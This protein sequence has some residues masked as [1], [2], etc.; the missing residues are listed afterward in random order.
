MSTCVE[1]GSNHHARIRAGALRTGGLFWILACVW[2]LATPQATAAP[3]TL[4]PAQRYYVIALDDGRVFVDL[5]RKDGIFEKQVLQVFR[6]NVTFDHPVTGAKLVGTTYL[7]DITLVEISD[8][9]SIA[10]AQPSIL[11]QLKPGYEVRFRPQDLEAVKS[12][13]AQL[14]VLV[15]ELALETETWEQRVRREMVRYNNKN[16]MI[17][18]YTEMVQ[19]APSDA[20]SRTQMDFTYRLFRGV[21]AVRFGLGGMNGV[22][23]VGEDE[24]GEPI[25]DRVAYYFGYSSLELKLAPY[26]SFSPI[27][28]M[29]LNNSG[30]GYGFGVSAR[31]GPELGTNLEIHGATA[32]VVGAQ[33]GLSYNHYINERLALSGKVAWENYVTGDSDHPS[34]RV[35][36]GGHYDVLPTI[37][38]DV[39]GG[40]GGRDVQNIGPTFFVGLTYNF[41]TGLWWMQELEDQ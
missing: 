8:V 37:R 16:N 22:G 26:F 28:Q 17:S 20:Y 18:A 4:E 32:N 3:V 12:Q 14:D 9:F 5:G 27:F 38:L 33:L 6:T 11:A 24:L 10:E 2:A 35:M 39:R 29:G 40:I 30:V 25:H 13:R 1:S 36:L 41:A 31:L 34:V 7:G 19:F 23:Q 21:Y 15:R